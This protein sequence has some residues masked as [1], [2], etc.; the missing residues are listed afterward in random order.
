MSRLQTREAH[1]I[2]QILQR[3][4]DER[5]PHERGWRH[6]RRASAPAPKACCFKPPAVQQV[7]DTLLGLGGGTTGGARIVVGGARMLG[8]LVHDVL[9]GRVRQIGKRRAHTGCPRRVLVRHRIHRLT[10]V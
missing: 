3:S 8:Q 4:G 6:Y 1:R 5:R 10:R 7:G 2:P 9:V